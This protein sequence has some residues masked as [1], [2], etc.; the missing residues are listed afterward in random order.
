MVE[1][2]TVHR[3]NKNGFT[4]W[5]DVEILED[6]QANKIEQDY[7]IYL[8][9]FHQEEISDIL[10]EHGFLPA[11]NEYVQIGDETVIEDIL[12]ILE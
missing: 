8:N 12:D 5:K 6:E 11:V 4:I 2:I 10:E 9:S 1:V 7:Y 3:D